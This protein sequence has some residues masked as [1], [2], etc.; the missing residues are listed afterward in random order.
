MISKL[1]QYRF[2]VGL[3][4]VLAASAVLNYVRVQGNGP[5][6]LA[7]EYLYSMNSRKSFL[8]EEPVA[9]DF[10][11]PLFNLVFSSTALCGDSFYACAKALNVLLL[12]LTL[13]VLAITMWR[14]MSK[15][16]VLVIT[17]ALSL[18]PV[19]VYTSLFL[20]EMLFFLLIAL[21]FWRVSAALYS[22]KSWDWALVGFILGLSALVKPHAW[23][24][25]L[26]IAVALIVLQIFERKSWRTHLQILF[27]FSGVAVMTR[28][29]LGFVISGPSSL[30][31]FGQ[32]VTRDT[33]VGLGGAVTEIDLSGG[34]PGNDPVGVGPLTGAI[35]GFAPQLQTHVTVLIALM[36]PLL[37][38]LILAVIYSSRIDLPP[39]FRRLGLVVI[40]WAL[41][42][43]IQVALFSGWVTGG[44]DDH[45]TRVLARYYDFMLL[46]IPTATF[47]V[48]QNSK[49]A[50][51]KA[52]GRIL[53]TTVILTV[54]TFGF[55]GYFAGLTI[56]IADAPALA[57]LVV[58]NST[59]G[60]VSIVGVLC[61]LVI[62]FFPKW[63]SL[64]TATFLVPA[65]ILTGVQTHNQYQI[66]R[67][68]DSP[69]DIV[70][71]V[72]REKLGDLS[73]DEIHVIAHSRFQATNIAFWLDRENTDY[74]VLTPGFVDQSLFQDDVAVLVGTGDFEFP[75]GYEILWQGASSWIVK[76]RVQAE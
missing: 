67:G 58:D 71:L 16:L 39:R 43:L 33:V 8:W 21:T 19:S 69:E 53:V 17:I 38:A 18:S 74:T 66:A 29:V 57:G 11:N 9:G 44:G 23:L 13:L 2:E 60:L 48:L 68:Q 15:W 1:F 73:D 70:G 31:I 32:Y 3:V 50:K 75:T 72:A 41:V 61:L 36:A 34:G 76:L 55:S 42:L 64:G 49:F 51:T 22:E 27:M 5:T 54:S 35:L 7:D 24:T 12:V 56:Q 4:L 30:A 40:V 45:S 28:L 63:T 52:V 20:P 25:V 62:A 65:L 10:S 37:A 26:S 46:L 6:I 47:I 14:T 59:Y